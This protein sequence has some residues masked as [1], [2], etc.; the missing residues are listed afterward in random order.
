MKKSIVCMFVL[1]LLPFVAYGAEGK[2]AYVDLNRA[3]NESRQG[4]EAIKT[5]EDMVLEKQAVID[6]K[7]EKI[8]A[9]EQ[10]LSKQSSVLTPESISE[11]KDTHEK[12]LRD[13]QRMVQD[14]QKEIQDT[15]SE[16]MKAI[17]GEIRKMIIII[18][19]EEKYT[20][21]FETAESGLLYMPKALDITDTVIERFSKTAS[22]PDIKK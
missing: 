17:L 11:K 4:K 14:T 6:A 3:L 2:F 9:L 13:Y 15:Q 5:L 12:L 19:E 16:L 21:I 8:K 22:S 10:E 18:G 20:A 7:G 1:W